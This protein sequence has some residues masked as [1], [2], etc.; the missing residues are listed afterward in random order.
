VS[1]TGKEDNDILEVV[2]RNFP[3]IQDR[4]LFDR[5]SAVLAAVLDQQTLADAEEKGE[6]GAALEL[7]RDAAAVAAA[8]AELTAR[9]MHRLDTAEARRRLGEAQK[10]N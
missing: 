1:R 2:V 8:A 9:L 5:L 7:A 3:R 6:P 4:R 10:Q